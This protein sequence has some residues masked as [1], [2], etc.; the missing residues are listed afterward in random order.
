[1][2]GKNQNYQQVWLEEALNELQ[3]WTAIYPY[4]DHAI[5]FLKIILIYRTLKAPVMSQI[6]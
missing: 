6:L 5:I 2:Q 1:M 4:M 3:N